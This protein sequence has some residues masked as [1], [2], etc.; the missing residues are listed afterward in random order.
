MEVNTE[1]LLLREMKIGDISDNYVQALNDPRIVEMT[2]ARHTNWDRQK[3]VQY[4]NDSNISGLSQLIGIFLK[5]DKKHIGNIRLSGFSA[6]HKRV[7][8]GIML[9]D[10][11]EWGKGY[12]TEALKRVC[13]YVFG[14]LNLHKICADYYSINVASAKMFNKA[15]FVIEGVFKEHFR[16][17][18]RYIDS[19]RVAIFK[20]PK[21]R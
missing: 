2:E 12:A 8:L 14:E 5:K 11:S 9:F 18:E 7:D 10:M 17:N 13:Q 6:I 1:N 20:H 19:V 4:I 16:L 21:Q 15:G 3:V